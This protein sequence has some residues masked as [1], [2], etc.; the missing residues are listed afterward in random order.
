AQFDGTDE[1]ALAGQY[2]HPSRLREKSQRLTDRSLGDGELLGEVALVD[3][4]TGPALHSED[5]VTQS[6]VHVV[7]Q[8]HAVT[9]PGASWI[10]QA[11]EDMSITLRST[12]F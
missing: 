10:R 5:L 12:G 2:H 6:V 4:V 1:I 3:D 11:D 9:L 7:G 8:G